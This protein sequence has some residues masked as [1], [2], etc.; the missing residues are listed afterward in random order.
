M[1]RARHPALV[2]GVSLALVTGAGISAAH[3]THAKKA[4]KK[5]AKKKKPA[6]KSEILWAVVR[7]AVAPAQPKILRGRG[8]VKVTRFGAGGPYDQ[9]RGFTVRFSRKIHKCAYVATVR[10]GGPGDLSVPLRTAASG[11]PNRRSIYVTVEL[12]PGQ[13]Q[14]SP[15]TRDPSFFVAA[16]C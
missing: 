11:T 12:L 6:P 7:G 1:R 8:V 5:V 2:L 15:T 10:N 14:Y 4:V 16:I 13:A 9:A 3:D